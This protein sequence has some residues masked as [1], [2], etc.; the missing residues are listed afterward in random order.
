MV[1][2][3]S[4][5][6]LKNESLINSNY[7]NKNPKTSSLYIDLNKKEYYIQVSTD[8]AITAKVKMK[9]TYEGDI[10]ED[11]KQFF[12]DSKK[13]IGICHL[14]D[15]V[16][17]E[18]NNES[19]IFYADKDSYDLNAVV[20]PYEFQFEIF[21]ELKE[22]NIIQ[23]S[24]DDY[25]ALE[26]ASKYI[27]YVEKSR[28]VNQTVFIRNTN[29]F[30]LSLSGEIFETVT[31]LPNMDLSVSAVSFILNCGVGVNIFQNDRHERIFNDEIDVIITKRIE[32][33]VFEVPDFQSDN[34]IESYFHDSY[35]KVNKNE[36][37]NFLKTLKLFYN[38]LPNKI[39]HVNV[40]QKDLYCNIQ[41]SVNIVNRV[42]QVIESVNLQLDFIF[43]L[44]A[45]VLLKALNILEG[46]NAI[47]MVSNKSITR[48]IRGE[49]ITM[50]TPLCNIYMDENKDEHVVFKRSTLKEN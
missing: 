36:F 44:D 33:S 41:S 21:D 15:S 26:K 9:F 22:S 25:Y 29:M 35:L 43:I 49:E 39:I 13:F 6:F 32:A 24:E 10:P 45:E 38:E 50:E 7:F 2:I 16:N 47:I 40:D 8:G 12:V 34:F 18:I 17:I 1:T 14:Y 46:E 42:F 28:Y 37:V 20:D 11:Y 27:P 4:K 30:S 48:N 31:A 19:I 5:D 3:N 23:I